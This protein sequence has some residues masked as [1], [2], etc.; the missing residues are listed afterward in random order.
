VITPR[1]SAPALPLDSSLFFKLVRVV[2][3]T[4]RP[5]VETLARTHQLSL[6]EW[7]V[8]V[9]LASRPGVA[10]SDLA[11][12]TGLDKMSISRAVAALSRHGR[13]CKKVDAQDGRR[14]LLRLNAAG[15]RVF[16]TIGE[17]AKQREV[18]LFGGIDA[19][20]L[21]RLDR[22]MDQLLAALSEGDA[23]PPVVAL[24]SLGEAHAVPRRPRGLQ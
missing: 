12:S 16:R 3:L 18:Q 5:F 1:R 2:N 14:T 8:M 10:A 7:R 6:N 19:A 4:A 23:R 22:L 17:R 24:P 13:I 9:V 20:E 15:E 11:A 21:Q